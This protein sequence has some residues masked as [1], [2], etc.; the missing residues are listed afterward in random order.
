[1]NYKKA[2]IVIRRFLRSVIKVLAWVAAISLTLLLLLIV[3]N[4]FTR[5]L[6][7]TPVLGT[8]ELVELLLVV[9]VLFVLAHTE[10]QKGHVRVELV[11]SRLSKRV[12]AII[13][14]IIY[15]IG[16]LFFLTLSWQGIDR[17]LSYLFPTVFTTNILNIPIAPFMFIISIGSFVL[18]LE[19]LL[20]CICP[21]LSEEEGGIASI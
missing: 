16:T 18:A 14:R 7:K 12:N 11:T 2:C 1:M 8:I 15:F 13:E 6:F 10:T 21:V 4:V 5:F 20:N 3:I 19:M 9:V 17:M